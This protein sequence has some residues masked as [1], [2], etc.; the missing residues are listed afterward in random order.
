[1]LFWRR[2]K[3]KWRDRILVQ[4]DVV[5]E[6]TC[7]LVIVHYFFTYLPEKIAQRFTFVSA[8]DSLIFHQIW[9]VIYLNNNLSFAYIMVWLVS[10]EG[11]HNHLGDTTNI[12]TQ[13]ILSRQIWQFKVPILGQQL[14]C[15]WVKS[16]LIFFLA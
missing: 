11:D 16:K 14:R 6:M 10:T 8:F 5:L 1:M 9:H 2:R 15:L 7:C 12:I 13:V 3:K 4:N